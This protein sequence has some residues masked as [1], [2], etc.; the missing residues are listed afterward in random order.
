MRIDVADPGS[1]RLAV[2]A[3]L[4]GA[5]FD[6]ATCELRDVDKTRADLL[7]LAADAPDALKMLRRL[8]DDG[9]RPDVPVILLGTPEGTTPIPEGPAFGAELVLCRPVDE[10]HLVEGARRLL[11]ERRAER[12]IVERVP[13]HT[14]ELREREARDQDEGERDDPSGVSAIRSMDLEPSDEGDRGGDE[15]DDRKSAPA[16]RPSSPPSPTGISQ[17]ERRSEI[18]LSAV[19]TGSG[20]VPGSTADFAQA[21]ISDSL[22]ALLAAADRRVFPGLAAIDVSIPAG[23]ASARE[24]VPDELFDDASPDAEGEDEGLFVVAPLAS[25]LGASVSSAPPR[26]ARPPSD[27]P[28]EREKKTSPG[29]PLSLGAGFKLPNPLPPR[30]EALASIPMDEALGPLDAADV[31]RLAILPGAMIRAL[32]AIVLGRASVRAIVTSPALDAELTF[33]RGELARVAGPVARLALERMGRTAADE[34]S[35]RARLTM[36]VER[37]ELSSAAEALALARGE[38]DLL[39][40]VALATSGEAVFHAA[41]DE[42]VPARLGPTARLLGSIGAGARGACVDALLAP[43][44]ANGRL[45][46]TRA[47][48]GVV[49]ALGVDA[50]LARFFEA[51]ED[52]VLR[53]ELARASRLAA[54]L[55]GVAALLVAAGALTIT[56]GRAEVAEVDVRAI[57]LVLREH[58]ARADDADYFTILG[59]RDDATPTDIAAAHDGRSTMLRTL[60]LEELGLGALAPLRAAALAALDEARECLADDALRSR[61]ARALA[62][63]SPG[64]AG[65]APSG[66]V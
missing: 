40:R 39:A 4:V 60:P 53:L 33:S 1:E 5:G 22:R 63:G 55:P 54:E 11:R 64:G 26:A 48:G 32:A 50:D 23:E 36:G 44:G 61:Y 28:A 18:P 17:I 49:A 30:A 52:G 41:R 19:T 15:R 2:V 43:L 66:A 9:R 37:G 46:A 35:A 29:T 21:A 45:D 24:L 12:S 42:D 27:P 57:E 16:A 62:A 6:V 14:L 7:V 34:P 8:R 10:T 31:R 20:S 25:V 51:R 59:V 58:A 56:P 38:R 47:L 13:E 3:A 65:A